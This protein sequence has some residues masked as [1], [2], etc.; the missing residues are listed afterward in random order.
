MLHMKKEAYYHLQFLDLDDLKP[1]S[2][3]LDSSSMD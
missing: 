1:E 3:T 2:R